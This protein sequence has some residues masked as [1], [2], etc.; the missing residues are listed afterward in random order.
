MATVLFVGRFALDTGASKE[1]ESPSIKFKAIDFSLESPYDDSTITIADFE[2]KTLVVNFF[3]T[4]CFSCRI[5]IPHFVSAWPSYEGT[6]AVFLAIDL[7]EKK[8]IVRK[9]AEETGMTYPIGIDSTAETIFKYGVRVLPTTIFI[10]KN[11]VVVYVY[12]GPLSKEQLI[13][14]I[15][16]TNKFSNELA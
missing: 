6:D 8:P 15:N 13:S 5:E 12:E 3:A 2:G 11:G 14:L 4:W 10:N 1:M 9:F 16:Y 7:Q